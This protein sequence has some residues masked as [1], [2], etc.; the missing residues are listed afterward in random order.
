MP[1]YFDSHPRTDVDGIPGLPNRV[2]SVRVVNDWGPLPGAFRI[3][4]LHRNHFRFAN[5]PSLMVGTDDT[6]MF[7]GPRFALVFLWYLLTERPNS[8]L[9]KIVAATGLFRTLTCGGW[10]YVT[11][12]DDHKWHDVFMV[13]YLV[14]T[15]PWTLGCLALSP[16][17]PKAIRYRKTLAGLFF[18]T[19]VPLAYFFIQHKVHKVPGGM[20]I[21]CLASSKLRLTV[22][23]PTRSTLSLS[24]P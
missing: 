9:P 6:D 1:R 16:P 11:S 14:T 13:S 24:G 10:T 18:G 12:T 17:N 5:C 21:L 8:L 2:V 23:Q 22:M 19:I 7:V 20:V 15:I 4:S 3:P